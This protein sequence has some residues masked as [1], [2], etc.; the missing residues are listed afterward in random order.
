[1][2]IPVERRRAVLNT[3]D[4]LRDLMVDFNV[5][6]EIRDN[7]YHLLKHYP[8]DYDMMIA[9]EQAPTIFGYEDE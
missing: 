1:M 8:T 6:K 9:G 2:T 7:A 3:R 5:S 4:F